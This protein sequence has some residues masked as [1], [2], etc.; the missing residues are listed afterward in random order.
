MRKEERRKFTLC[1]DELAVAAFLR[2]DWNAGA[3]NA[4]A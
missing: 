3:T 2:V 1:R 4:A